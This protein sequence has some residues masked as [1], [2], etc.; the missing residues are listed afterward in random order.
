M[1]IFFYSAFATKEADLCRAAIQEHDSRLPIYP[2]PG[3]CRLNSFESLRLRSGDIL[4]LFAADSVEL[5]E[6]LTLREE[7]E[8]FRVFLLVRNPESR[9]CQ[10]KAHLLNPRLVISHENTKPLFAMIDNML[11]KNGSGMPTS[12]QSW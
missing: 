3:G 1:N 2:L 12:A 9:C 6:L 5:E 7:F 11:K 8:D 10:D 4:I